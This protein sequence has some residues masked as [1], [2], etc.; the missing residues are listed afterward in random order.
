MFHC[1]IRPLSS[2]SL[3]YKDKEKRDENEVNESGRKHPTDHRRPNGGLGSCSGTGGYGKWQD[4]EEEC[5]GGHDDRPES[6]FHCPKSRLEQ[7][8]SV[9]HAMLCELND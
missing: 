2:E 1:L 5:Q 4:A 7:L 3:G 9:L 6:G 8:L